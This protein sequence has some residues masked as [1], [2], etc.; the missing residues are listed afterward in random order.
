MSKT[1]WIFF[2]ADTHSLMH[3]L[4]I[5]KSDSNQDVF[6]R[7]KVFLN[8]FFILLSTKFRSPLA[9]N[10]DYSTILNITGTVSGKSIQYR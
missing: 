3:L 7:F 10:Y 5:H 9:E 2:S 4:E 6:F 8:F 1:N